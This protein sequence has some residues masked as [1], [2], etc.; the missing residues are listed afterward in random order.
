MVS[1]FLS[2]LAVVGARHH[3]TIPYA[4]WALFML[5]NC[6]VHRQS[7]VCS[8]FCTQQFPPFS[9]SV[10]CIFQSSVGHGISIDLVVELE[11]FCRDHS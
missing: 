7:N 9:I 11:K 6:S 8:N 1:F 5:L 10:G 4:F 2:L 3:K